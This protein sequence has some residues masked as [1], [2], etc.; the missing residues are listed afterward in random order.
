MMIA[1]LLN[2]DLIKLPLEQDGKEEVIAELIDLLV[3][4]QKVKDRD[5]AFQAILEREKVMS[6]G[7]GDSVAIPHG[8][9]DGVDEVV[10]AFGISH[11]DIN[12][13]SIDNKPVRLVFLLIATP[14]AKGS[15]LKVLSRVSR[16]L[17]KK[18]FRNNL[19]QAESPKQVLNLIRQEEEAFFEN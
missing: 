12:F 13:K 18:D 6:T 11:K 4:N 8:K 1:D 14:N 15:H 7:V 10:G 3:S 2:T 5:R 17:N 9:T 19:L 16:L